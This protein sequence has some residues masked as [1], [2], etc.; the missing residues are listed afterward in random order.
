MKCNFEIVN[1]GLDDYQSFNIISEKL[2]I[3]VDQDGF[4]T[5]SDIS[6]NWTEN[7]TIRQIFRKVI[8]EKRN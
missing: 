2:V 5:M 3:Y 8:N 6:A 4:F 7:K 1:W